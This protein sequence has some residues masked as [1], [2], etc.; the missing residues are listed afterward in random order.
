MPRAHITL[1]LFSK[2]W[3]Q[4]VNS[5]CIIGLRNHPQYYEWLLVF[6]SSTC[7]LV[8]KRLGWCYKESDQHLCS[9][10]KLDDAQPFHGAWFCYFTAMTKTHRIDKWINLDEL[11]PLAMDGSK[12]NQPPTSFQSNQ[13]LSEKTRKV[14][15]REC[16]IVVGNI[17]HRTKM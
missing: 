4:E 10:S 14:V 8:L 17:L 12:H 5:T 6:I 7:F 13:R 15:K 16:C 11:D 9:F 2:Q 3:I 1:I